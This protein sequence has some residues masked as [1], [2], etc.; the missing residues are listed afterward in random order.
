MTA[1]R[2]K[3]WYSKREI[4][5]A[6][7][8][9]NLAQV[10]RTERRIAD[11]A[12]R[13]GWS[14]TPGLTRRRAGKGGGLEHHLTLLPEA[15]K[16]AVQ[17]EHAR[18]IE[19]HARSIQKSSSPAPVA[20]TA[21]N[22]RQRSVMEARAAVLG[23]IETFQI[24]HGA[25]QRQAML[26]FVH[27]PRD[28]GLSETL[29][30]KAN[31]RGNEDR[32]ISLRTL[33]RWI[34][35]RD[36]DGVQALAPRATR[37]AKPISAAFMAFLKYYALPSKPCA[38]EALK[39]YR[40]NLQD[41][42][43]DLTMDEVR[44]TLRNKLNNI[45]K[46]VG[47]EGLH[48]LKARLAYVQR[49]T[50]NL[51]PTTIYTADG[52]TFDAEVAH[53]ITGRPFKP[54]ITSVLDVATRRCVGFAVSLK[55]NVIAVTEAL[56]NACCDFGIPAIFYVDRGPGY[57][58]KAFDADDTGLMGRLSITKM[59]S[60]PYNSQ[61]R[62]IIER[63]NGSVWNPLARTLP[64]YLGAEMDR[65]A[66]KF[67][68]KKTRRDIA[69]Y[70]TSRLLTPWADF[71]DMCARAIAKYNAQPHSGLAK[72]DDPHTGKRRHLSPD[73]AW[74]QFVSAG[75]EPVPVEAEMIDDLFRPYE[76]RVARRGEIEWN[77]NTF[78]HL[79]LE[80]YHGERVMVGYD[81]AQA[82]RLWVRE[83][84]RSDEGEQPGRLICIAIFGG[85]KTDYV[86]KT[87]QRSAEERRAKGR[88]RLLQGKVAD[89]EAELSPV[90]LLEQSSVSPIIIEAEATPQVSS[91]VI[92]LPSQARRRTFSSDVELALWAIDHPN[93]LTSNQL[94]VLRDCL[95][96]PA[97]LEH[98]R[99]SG[100]DA[101][102]LRAVIRAAA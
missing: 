89:V 65:E 100:I 57:K 94:R 17:A 28:F 50:D 26:S 61:A 90:A 64:T 40:E 72:I 15:L 76:V 97:A 46:H 56:R 101:E 59:H 77:S 30:V 86:P 83:I 29:I 81:F 4:A 74:A 10:P 58:N 19:L 92:E 85:N 8:L 51:W 5:D 93:E 9:H 96:R 70:G 69:T 41:K 68:H 38:T 35:Q 43:L 21:M 75:F 54:E 99:V 47:R 6:A 67:V 36:E 102:A 33:Q 66:A 95:T 22:A 80:A 39:R 23:A 60:L 63:F 13:A 44:Y 87:Y 20:V 71:Q 11:L 24:T 73:D 62:G 37:D 2:L 14:D 55:E 34:R 25:S 98:F 78:F 53:P 91:V 49:S 16:A 52:K 45:E 27:E 7:E 79:D 48:T 88:L 18:A 42:R 32:E 3:E 84:D 1:P 31:D 82:N 12:E